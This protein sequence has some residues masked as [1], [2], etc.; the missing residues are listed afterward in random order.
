[1]LCLRLIVAESQYGAYWHVLGGR[2]QLA[3]E[4]WYRSTSSVWESG[5][6]LC[7]SEMSTCEVATKLVQV[8][9]LVFNSL[10]MF[11]LF[12]CTFLGFK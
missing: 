7:I 10:K 4:E 1:M 2:G 11:R 8:P 3:T 6:P 12:V 5:Q 9:N